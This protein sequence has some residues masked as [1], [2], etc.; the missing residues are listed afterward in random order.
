MPPIFAQ[1]CYGYKFLHSRPYGD[2]MTASSFEDRYEQLSTLLLTTLKAIN[3]LSPDV[4][5]LAIASAIGARKNSGKGHELLDAVLHEIFPGNLPS[6][7]TSKEEL[8][9]CIERLQAASA[10]LSG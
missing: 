6:D 10:K 2:S 1:F 5:R 9:K 4:S 3:M 8:V 7:F